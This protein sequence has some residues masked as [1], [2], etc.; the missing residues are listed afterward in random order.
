LEKYGK[1]FS[2]CGKSSFL[3]LTLRFHALV[4]S[5]IKIFG[6]GSEKWIFLVGKNLPY[7]SNS[8]MDENSYCFNDVIGFVFAHFFESYVNNAV[9]LIFT[10]NI[11][12]RNGIETQ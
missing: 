11:S 4:N 9:Q 2:N 10:I 1:L 12:L 7:F 5:G 6:F 3:T 8:Y